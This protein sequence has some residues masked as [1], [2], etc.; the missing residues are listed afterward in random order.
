MH[1]LPHGLYPP[2]VSGT[3]FSS[4]PRTGVGDSSRVLQ[5][6]RPW[7]ARKGQ[8]TATEK[9]APP[10][11]PVT[12]TRR[13]PGQETRYRPPGQETL[14]RRPEQGTLRHRPGQ[15]TRRRRP[16]Q[17][18]LRR[19]TAGRDR[20]RT[21]GTA[22]RPPHAP[23]DAVTAALAAALAVAGKTTETNTPPT[24]P[25]AKSPPVSGNPA[26]VRTKPQPPVFQGRVKHN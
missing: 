4:R 24:V 12:P 13:P 21:A 9:P 3:L 5:P 1:F 2:M 17:G 23:G 10:G 6:P 15:G 20:P 22:P 14:R 7:P 26:T 18:I 19:R 25:G 11:Q 8:D 16:G